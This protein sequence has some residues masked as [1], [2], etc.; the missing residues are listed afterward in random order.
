MATQIGSEMTFFCW[1][2][3]TVSWRRRPNEPHH[4]IRLFLSP[5]RIVQLPNPNSLLSN[6][7]LELNPHP[8]GPF[9][10]HVRPVVVHAVHGLSHGEQIR[11]GRDQDQACQY[12]TDPA[13]YHADLLL[14]LIWTIPS[15]LFFGEILLILLLPWLCIPG[16]SWLVVSPVS[17]QIVYFSI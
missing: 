5:N 6:L 7:L 1:A 4:C 9:T 10:I 8:N 13:I 11:R 16:A 17:S 2:V 3:L 14:I 12:L 15:A